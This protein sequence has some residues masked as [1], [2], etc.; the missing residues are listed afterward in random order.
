MTPADAAAFHKSWYGPNNATLFVV[1][2]T[3][4]AEITPKLEAAL[5][6]WIDLLMGGVGMRRGRRDPEH[7]RVLVDAVHE[8]SAAYHV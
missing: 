1:G 5:R 2:D 4:L 3:T 8:L 7:V 6:G